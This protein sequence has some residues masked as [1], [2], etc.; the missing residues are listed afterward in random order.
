[1]PISLRESDRERLEQGLLVGEDLPGGEPVLAVEVAVVRDIDEDRLAGLAGVLHRIEDASDAAID[2]DQRGE[3][4]RPVF[5][6]G[7]TR[8]VGERWEGADEGRLVGHVRFVERRG[9]R[10]RSVA[11]PP[12]VLGVGLRVRDASA[13]AGTVIARAMR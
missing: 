10:S 1:M 9:L 13:A 6:D 4:A 8:L 2:A 5:L 3:R 11:E 12:E 7:I